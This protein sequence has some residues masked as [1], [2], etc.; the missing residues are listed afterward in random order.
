MSRK[1]DI[2]AAID[3]VLGNKVLV[4]TTT[5]ADLVGAGVPVP[6]GWGLRPVLVYKDERRNRKHPIYCL[7]A[8]KPLG[9]LLLTPK[10]TWEPKK[11]PSEA[12]LLF[13]RAIDSPGEGVLKLIADACDESGVGPADQGPSFAYDTNARGAD[14]WRRLWWTGTISRPERRKIM[15]FLFDLWGYATS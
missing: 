6:D 1:Q 10:G 8:A 11:Q 14:V 7:E 15:A 3:V 9:R 13:E 12:K 5:T 2:Q 4:R